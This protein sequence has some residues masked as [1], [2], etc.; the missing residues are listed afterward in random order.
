MCCRSSRQIRAVEKDQ[1]EI[2]TVKFQYSGN[3]LEAAEAR[4]A[5]THKMIFMTL[6]PAPVTGLEYQILSSHTEK[7]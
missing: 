1:A 7:R 2:S 3:Y 6:V 5:T 4:K